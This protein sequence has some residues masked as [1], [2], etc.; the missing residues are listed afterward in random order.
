MSDAFIVGEDFLSVDGG[1]YQDLEAIDEST[2][3]YRSARSGPTPQLAS[4]PSVGQ[5]LDHAAT[6]LQRW[7]CEVEQPESLAVLVRDSRQRD[8][9]VN[10]LAERGVQVR[11]VDRN[12]PR[13]GAPVVMTMHRAKG[14][15]F[16]RVLLFGV[17]RGSIPIN[18]RDYDYD[19]SDAADA[20]LRER[21]LLY[22]A[23]S[24]ARDELVVSWNGEQ[25]ELLPHT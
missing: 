20:L 8:L 7:I 24:R 13:A 3:G 10:G 2:Q 15:E 19:P 25:S 4:F 17:S 11:A 1:D 16:T 9:V 5:E 18:L 22:V 14:M 21:S 12:E 6:V 23:A